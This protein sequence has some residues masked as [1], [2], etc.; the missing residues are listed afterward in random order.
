MPLLLGKPDTRAH[1]V[2][3]KTEID[4]NRII[5]KVL[6]FA[7]MFLNTLQSFKFNRRTQLLL[8]PTLNVAFRF[9][10]TRIA[11]PFPN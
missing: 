5:M 3:Q 1:K 8:P 2:L 9:F 10:E 11:E 4:R 7:N 6:T